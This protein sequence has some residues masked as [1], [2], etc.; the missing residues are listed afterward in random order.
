MIWPAVLILRKL[1]YLIESRQL[2][3]NAN[4]VGQSAN[5]P[6]NGVLQMALWSF[7]VIF[8]HLRLFNQPLHD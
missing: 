1:T 7:L 6:P 8:P 5:L 2:A 4:P 3:K